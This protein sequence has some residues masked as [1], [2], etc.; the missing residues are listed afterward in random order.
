MAAVVLNVTSDESASLRRALDGAN[1]DIE[2]L[3]KKVGELNAVGAETG[4]KV[5]KPFMGIAAAAGR[6]VTQVTALVGGVLSLKEALD[7]VRKM[8]DEAGNRVMSAEQA[9]RRLATLSP[10][11][12]RDLRAAARQLQ[13]SGLERGEAFNRAFTFESAGELRKVDLLIAAERAGMNPV[14]LAEG[15]NKFKSA[16]HEGAGT[17]EQLI[18]KAITAAGPVPGVTASEMFTAA[19][20]ATSNWARAGGQDESLLATLAIVAQQEK[21]AERSAQLIDSG[22]AAIEAVRKDLPLGMRDMPIEQILERIDDAAA[23]GKLRR[24]GKRVDLKGFVGSEMA[25]KLVDIYNK[26]LGDI[27]EMNE[28]INQSQDATGTKRDALRQAEG[29]NARIPHLVASE[30]A[31]VEKSKKELGLEDKFAT[32]ELQV[33]AMFDARERGFRDHGFNEFRILLDRL[34]NE[35]D[36]WA[37]G[38]F[39]GDRAYLEFIN[40]QRGKSG[41]GGIEGFAPGASTELKRAVKEGIREGIAEA[42]KSNGPS[43]PTLQ[44]PDVETGRPGLH[45]RH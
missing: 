13:K 43:R 6:A 14:A 22:V 23:A 24:G 27:Q 40:N 11:R 20:A 5:E 32:P 26:R 44:G 39:G 33:D 30:A 45:G 37:F 3:K 10:E 12:Q 34:G 16:F 41:P 4:E 31:R 25:V 15:I 35:L 17:S 29:I 42:A 36:R 19:S 21:N 2:K 9:E 18:N 8:S 1:R 28:A 38:L 7:A